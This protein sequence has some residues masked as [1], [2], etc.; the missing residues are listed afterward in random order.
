M[1]KQHDGKGH[2]L[3]RLDAPGSSDARVIAADLPEE[4][5]RT[6]LAQY[7]AGEQHLTG[8]PS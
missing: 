8:A 1:F 4:E 5:A 6:L 7:R 3:L 2:G